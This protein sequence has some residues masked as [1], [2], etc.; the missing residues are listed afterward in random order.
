M[1]SRAEQKAQARAQRIEYERKLAEE[2]RRK[3]RLMRV[4]GVG[5]IAVILIV[6]AIVVSSG[7][8]TPPPVKLGSAQSKVIANRV[9]SLLNGI[10]Q[11]GGNNVLGNPSAPVQVTF[12]G[13]LECSACDQFALPTNVNTSGGV[14]G[15]GYEDQ[16][17]S[18]YVRTG[19]ASIVYR[20][21]DTATGN[22]ATPGEFVPQ[23]AAALA[24][25][26][27][28]K[29]WY[30]IQTFYN[31]QRPEGT[32]YV[33]QSFLE[34]IAKQVPG[35][36]YSKWLSD[37]GSSSLAAQVQTDENAASAAGYRYTPTIVIKG[38]KGQAPVIQ[39]VPSS[40]TEIQSAIN[41]VS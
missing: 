40:W 8:S 28:G 12:Y 15:S 38:P 32:A 27:Q 34:G 11:N 16:L 17:I 4:G 21:L 41:Q 6:V 39:S 3:Q 37:L 19:K 35:L 13:D 5:L 25:G 36:N 22:G 1:A 10:P 2:A 9:D 29:A 7:N 23:Q 14:K 30:F 31:E 24:A 20:S 33:N 26:L 18:Q